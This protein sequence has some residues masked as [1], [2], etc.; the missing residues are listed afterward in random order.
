MFKSYKKSTHSKCK[1][2]TNTDLKEQQMRY[3]NI[4]D[5]QAYQPFSVYHKL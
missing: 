2:P 1:N 3:K 5:S 4:V